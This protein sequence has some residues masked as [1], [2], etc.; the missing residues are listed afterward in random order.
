MTFESETRH[1][2]QYVSLREIMQI[3][4]TWRRLSVSGCTQWMSV[5]CFM[6]PLRVCACVGEC[7]VA[8]LSVQ[9]VCLVK[10]F[11]ICSE[12][13]HGPCSVF[14]GQPIW[15]IPPDAHHHACLPPAELH[16]QCLHVNTNHHERRVQ[17]RYD[18][19]HDW[20]NTDK[21]CICSPS[22]SGS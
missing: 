11:L 8:L 5:L 22:F 19:L 13:S 10:S 2:S 17:I 14:L 20:S 9:C 1:I 6:R 21:C 3:S 12:T 16:V 7:N 15:Q 4:E 18:G